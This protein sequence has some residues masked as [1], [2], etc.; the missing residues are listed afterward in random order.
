[1]NAAITAYL[2]RLEFEALDAVVRFY[3]GN[4]SAEQVHLARQHLRHVRKFA[5]SPEFT[6]RELFTFRRSPHQSASGAGH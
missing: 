6:Q 2:E 5:T 3:D 1:M 4:I